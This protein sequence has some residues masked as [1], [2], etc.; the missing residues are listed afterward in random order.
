MRALASIA[1]AAL[2]LLAA[3]A[4]FAQGT[5][6]AL[7][8]G[9]PAG[10]GPF[11]VPITVSDAAGT[12]LGIDR[13]AGQRI[14]A[15]AVTVRF[16]PAAAV[17]SAT[18]VRTGLLAGRM[19]VFET[20]ATGPGTI[21]WVGLFDESAGAVPFTQPPGTGG[22]TIL[23]LSVTLAPG[24]TVSASL[25]APTTTLSNQGGTVSES[26]GDAT[27]V[28]GPAVALPLGEPAAP[29]VPAAGPFALAVFALAVAAAGAP[30]ARRPRGPAP[31]ATSSRDPRPGALPRTRVAARERSS[32]AAVPC[33]G[34][35]CRPG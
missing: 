11:T 30:L 20:T 33:P 12:P 32:R 18:L 17:T 34:C 22:D 1:L 6:D 28:L 15:F 3:P 31:A 19:P 27:L 10:T 7:R 26:T 14:Q 23:S 21:T 13:P 16:A 25:D 24:A 8:F 5:Q 9:V 35:S 29:P 2:V 4:A